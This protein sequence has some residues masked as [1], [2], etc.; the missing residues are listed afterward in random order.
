MKWRHQEEAKNTTSGDKDDHVVV[1]CTGDVTHDVIVATRTTGSECGG[2]GGGV[3]AAAINRKPAS[4]M[5]VADILDLR[6][7]AAAAVETMT[8]FSDHVTSASAQNAA[9]DPIRL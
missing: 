1:T 8:S 3:P 7:A 2:G 4:V 5:S 9:I 6:V